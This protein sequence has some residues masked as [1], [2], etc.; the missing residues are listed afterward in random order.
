METGNISEKL[1]RGKHTTRHSELIEIS[2][3]YLVDTPGFSTLDIS[4][5]EKEDL[6]YTFP[7]FEEYN[8]LC[9][10]RGCLHYKEP[11]KK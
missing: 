9:K 5:I 7:D 11:K 2:N 4:F 1:K 8:N 3:G 6:K 10:F